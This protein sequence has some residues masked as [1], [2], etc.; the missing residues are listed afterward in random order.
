MEH[1]LFIHRFRV[2][3]ALGVD[4]GAAALRT[5]GVRGETCVKMRRIKR[6]TYPGWDVVGGQK[7]EEEKK[8]ITLPTV[9]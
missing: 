9:Q 3:E 2:S 7:E 1:A 4:G 8:N 6:R 5:A